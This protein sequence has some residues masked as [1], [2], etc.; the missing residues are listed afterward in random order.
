MNNFE[1]ISPDRKTHF[2]T[3]FIKRVPQY[4]A[5]SQGFTG[6]ESEGIK[7]ENSVIK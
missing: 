1:H 6:L 4:V 5:Y 7:N 2:I 3:F